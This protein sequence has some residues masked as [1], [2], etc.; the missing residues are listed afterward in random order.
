MCIAN[1]IVKA[2]WQ[3]WSKTP[4]EVALISLSWITSV[5]DMN[6]GESLKL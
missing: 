2:Y 1:L 3:K 4:D 6:A 5:Y